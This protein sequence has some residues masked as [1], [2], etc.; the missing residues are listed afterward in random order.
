[1][2][3]SV[4]ILALF[5]LLGLTMQGE[6]VTPAWKVYRNPRFNIEFRYPSNWM[7]EKCVS[8]Y[9]APDDLICEG[10]RVLPLGK[11]TD[12]YDM[13]FELKA[14][15]LDHVLQ[16]NVLYVK[17]KTGWVK[18][19]KYEDTQPVKNLT[20]HHWHGIYASASCMLLNNTNAQWDQ[21]TGDCLSVILHQNT[22]TAIFEFGGTGLIP[23][24]FALK[25]VIPSLRSI[26]P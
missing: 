6:A 15:S 3:Q 20:V 1:M 17:T 8:A 23:E 4:V 10:F 26:N 7:H 11:N 22:K 12:Y 13:M 9:A 5:C 25:N 16:E 18:N 24:T 19:G 14:K 21:H 2:T